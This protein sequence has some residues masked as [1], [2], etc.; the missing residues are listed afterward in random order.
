MLV[1]ANKSPI[2]AQKKHSYQ[3]ALVALKQHQPAAG[4][5]ERKGQRVWIYLIMYGHVH[6]PGL[7]QA[8]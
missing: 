2:E 1:A 4:F 5:V 8:A 3:Q 7:L 6:V